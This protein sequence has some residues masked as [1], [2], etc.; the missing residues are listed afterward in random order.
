VGNSDVKLLNQKVVD[1]FIS[2]LEPI[3]SLLKALKVHPNV[4]TAAGL[5]LSIICGWEF[6][7]GNFVTAGILLVLAG[8]CDVLDG[9]LARSSGRVSRTGAFFDSVI[10]RY[11]E[12]FIFMG[13]V[14][15]FDSS[16][17]DALLLLTL[18]GSLLTSYVRARAEGL[19]IEC[20]IGIMQRP[21]RLTY[22]SAGA[23]FSFLWDGLLI[24]AIIIVA[25]FSNV[26]AIQRISYAFRKGN[27]SV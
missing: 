13:L 19:G 15:H 22:L 11:S 16:I 10:D 7:L 14:A 8:I 1:G 25:I 18:G 12:I 5:F 6:Y 17:I 23:I 9:R 4:V 3:I 27:R 2:I 21:E 26:T 20:K 24:I